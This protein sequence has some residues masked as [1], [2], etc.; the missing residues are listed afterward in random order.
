MKV[1]DADD[2][3]VFILIVCPKKLQNK[4]KIYLAH[5]PLG[6]FHVSNKLQWI[7]LFV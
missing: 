3:F 1:A 5:T 2:I 6:Q 7:Q 4:D